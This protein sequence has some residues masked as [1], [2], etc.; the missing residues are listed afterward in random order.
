M[1]SLSFIF[2]ASLLNLGF[3]QADFTELVELSGE[4]GSGKCSKSRFGEVMQEIITCQNEWQKER[5]IA[6]ICSNNQNSL[7]CIDDYLPECWTS[8]GIKEY[9]VATLRF[10]LKILSSEQT[11]EFKSCPAYI[12]IIGSG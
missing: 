3:V 7:K 4:L 6:N 9:K 11:K 10:I 1:K 5:T 2:A 12:E 8:E